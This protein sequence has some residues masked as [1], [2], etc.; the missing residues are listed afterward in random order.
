MVG[1]RQINILVGALGGAGGGVLTNWLVEAIRSRDMPVQA[2]SIPGVAQRTGATTYYI[3]LITQSSVA[4]SDRR[5]VFGLYPRPGDIDVVIAS[6]LV[7][8]G[9]AM[10]NGFVTPER[11]TLI[12]ASER[13]YTVSEKSAAADA[14]YDGARVIKAGQELSLRPYMF[15]TANDAHGATLPLNAVLLGMVAGSNVLP[16]HEDDFETAIRESGVAV[17]RNLA[18]FAHGVAVANSEVSADVEELEAEPAAL[19]LP[20]RLQAAL[21]DVP[22]P[23]MPTVMLGIAKLMDYQS[24]RYAR[25][26]VERVQSIAALEPPGEETFALTKEAAR[27]L[28]LWMA[29][30]DIV[31][32]ADLK[33]RSSRFA[34]LRAEVGAEDGQPVRVQ[35]FLKPGIEEVAA[36]LPSVIGRWMVLRAERRGALDR[37]RVPLHLKTTTITG[38]ASLWLLA[39]LRV[40]RP[41][42]YRFAEEKR[43]IERWLEAVQQAA[44]RDYALACEVVGCVQLLKGYG[45]THRRGRETF[46]TILN[47]VVEWALAGQLDAA[48]VRQ[49]RE[50][51]LSDPEGSSFDKKIEELRERRA[52]LASAAE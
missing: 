22:E 3:E 6:E 18:G 11:T 50:A 8:A 49:A 48:G 38:F 27:H 51:A 31:L 41:L 13:Q 10:E 28:A 4:F 29:Y 30:E 12:A 37:A 17:A 24:A 7:E 20:R 14:R 1:P 21:E 46:V 16:L 43:L 42:G 32:V 47:R 33:S 26:Y 25:R 15:D 45:D 23:C 39:R 9:R 19:K 34:R 52:T 5:P 40:F 2:T 35:E 36:L 44:E